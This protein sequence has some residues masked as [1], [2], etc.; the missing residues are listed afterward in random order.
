MVE[1]SI[2]ICTRNRANQLDAALQALTDIRSEHEWEAIILDNGSTDHTGEVIA[3]FAARDSRFHHAHE[4]QPGLGAARDTAWRAARGRIVSF[5]D[6]D[7]YVATDYVDRLM[8]AFSKRP[9]AGYLGGR[10]LLHDPT[11]APVTIMTR[12]TPFDIPPRSYVAAGLLQGANLAFRRDVLEAIDGFSR[13]MGAGTPFPCEDIDAVAM[14]SWK[15]FAGGYDPG[16]TVSHHHG[17]K[18]A[19]I[20][21]LRSGYDAGR[22]AYFAKFI[23]RSESRKAYLAGFLHQ[24]HATPLLENVAR[25]WRYLVLG[26]RYLR[27]HRQVAAMLPFVGAVAVQPIACAILYGRA[28]LSGMRTANNA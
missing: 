7:C 20:A 10:I 3:E 21:R 5:T 12:E 27:R 9:Q 4:P 13:D 14:A 28:K 19:D 11:D 2:V 15:G 6:D 1:V 18:L 26:T 8:E 24:P 25:S 22:A 16:P 23:A 17:R